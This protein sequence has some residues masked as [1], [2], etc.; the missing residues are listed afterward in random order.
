MGKY[1]RE[2]GRVV[3]PL[4]SLPAERSELKS[5][6][7]RFRPKAAGGGGQKIGQLLSLIQKSL[8]ELRRTIGG[9]MPEPKE[10][11]SERL[12]RE[13]RLIYATI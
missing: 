11:L 2:I 7:G 9:S 3:I 8:M 12:E 4:E 10:T 13:F 6:Y 1:L 5:R